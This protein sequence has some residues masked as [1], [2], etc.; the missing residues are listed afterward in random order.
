MKVHALADDKLIRLRVWEDH[1]KDIWFYDHTSGAWYCVQAWQGK[2][3]MQL[4]DAPYGLPRASRNFGPFK[5]IR[6]ADAA[7]K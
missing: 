1:D 7:N 4:V 6:K 2:I 3:V 5:S